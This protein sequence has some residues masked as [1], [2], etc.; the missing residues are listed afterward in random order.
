MRG[1]CR[2]ENT[3]LQSMPPTQ[4]G[5]LDLVVHNVCLP[6]HHEKCHHH[7][8]GVA[9]VCFRAEGGLPI[10]SGLRRRRLRGTRARS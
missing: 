6:E 7:D 5:E 1:C 3:I 9:A 8:D 4:R 10:G 2:N